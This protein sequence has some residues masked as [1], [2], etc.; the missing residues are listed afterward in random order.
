MRHADSEIPDGPGSQKDRA[1]RIV[2]TV[3]FLLYTLLTVLV[4]Y[5]LYS[6]STPLVI[7]VALYM[8][9]NPVTNLF[10][11]LGVAR[12][13]AVVLAY[14]VFFGV[15][16]LIISMVIP[17]MIG[18]VK[19]IV[20]QLDLYKLK[21]VDLVQNMVVF[22]KE[23]TPDVLPLDELDSTQ[24]AGQIF[25][26]IGN[27]APRSLNILEGIGMIQEYVL[28]ALFNSIIILIASGFL[29][30]NGYSIYVKMMEL[31]PNRYFEMVIMMVSRVRSQISSYLRALG[32][33]WLILA[34]IMVPGYQMMGL[35]YG[36]FFGL[37]GA[38][39]NIIPYLGPALGIV[40]PVIMALMD[41]V[42]YWPVSGVL[43]V[44]GIAQAVD[45]FYNQPVLLAKSVQLNPLLSLIAIGAFQSLLG[46]FG[47]VIAVPLTGVILV[48]IKVMKRN[49]KAF[50]VV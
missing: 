21:L 43:I 41:N 33:Q 9:L 29:L 45:N 46:A 24:L 49:L 27:L 7:A 16:S 39:V 31:V 14:L 13:I 2:R 23:N 40:P 10:E 48:T 20:S 5:G 4:G 50:G 22:L 18:E 30:M 17:I 19:N 3:Y 44:F 1:T 15:L 12:P 26:I 42:G 37:Y 35:T 34:I 38:T 11:G 47:M 6:L 36:I 8:L 25:S 28:G 32:L